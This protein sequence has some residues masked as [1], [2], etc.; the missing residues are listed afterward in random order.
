MSLGYPLPRKV[1]G[2]GWL[3]LDGGKLS[4]SKLADGEHEG[5]KRNI[6]DPVELIERY[7]VDSLKYFLLREYTFGQDGQFTTE[8]M[9]QRVNADLANDLGN[10]LSRTT[11]MNDKY[12]GG[13][14]RR[15]D[16]LYSQGA[17]SA[18]C[19]IPKSAVPADRE[20]IALA[21]GTAAKV[22]KFMDGF[23]FNRALESIWELIARSN[24]YVDE[25]EPWLLAKD[26]SG[27][28]RLSAVLYNLAESLRIVSVLIQPYL[29]WSSERIR[30]Q[31][32]LNP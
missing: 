25:T 14:M 7:G 15:P 1:L 26:K 23:E 16:S 17:M 21:L 9:L 19:D 12:F 32:G 30:T 22:E 13:V 4:K 6:V 24:K 29:H 28:E 18:A 11:G 31:L 3:L 10:L 2:H 20:L 5:T 27:E 8:A